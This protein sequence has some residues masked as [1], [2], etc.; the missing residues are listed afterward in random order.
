LRLIKAKKSVIAL[1]TASIFNVHK[2]VP[3]KKLS[4]FSAE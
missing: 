1:D 4:I 2:V 3:E